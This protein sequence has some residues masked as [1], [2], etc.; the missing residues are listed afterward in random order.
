MNSSK[1]RYF[2]GNTVAQALVLAAR[3]FQL[4]P[5]RVAYRRVEKRQGFTKTP[6]RVVIEV[7][8]EHPARSAD[9]APESVSSSPMPVR[10]VAAIPP[11]PARMDRPAREG[12][13]EERQPA[14]P[15]PPVPREPLDLASLLIRA[16]QAVGQILGLGG[17]DLHAEVRLSDGSLAIDLTGPDRTL[18]LAEEGELLEAIETL[19]PRAIPGGGEGLSC[20]V[21]SDGFRHGKEEALKTLARETAAAVKASGRAVR[22]EPMAPGERRLVHMTLAEETGV[23]T[24]SEGDGLFKRVWINPA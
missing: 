4:D 10:Q 2:A 5:E 14:T 22:L 8:P 20:R 12:H 3:H 16:R 24:E 19:V 6:K 18:L 15:R 11:L 1:R 7:D 23:T 17:L 9:S 21:D 13:R